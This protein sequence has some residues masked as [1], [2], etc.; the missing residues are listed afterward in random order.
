MHDL[1]LAKK[2]IAAPTTHPLRTAVSKHKARLN[3]ELTKARLKRGFAS[4]KDLKRQVE[5]GS[6]D[7]TNKGADSQWPQIDS[8]SVENQKILLSHPRWVRINTLLSNL[9]EQLKTT[10]SNYKSVD[11]VEEVISA[12][13][14]ECN[15]G[16]LLHID[17]HVPNI[18]AVSLGSNIS[19]TH[20]YLNGSII[21]Q[22]KASCFPAYLLDPQPDGG[23]CLDACA[24]PGNKTTHLVAILESRCKNAD[25]PKVWAC[26]RDKTRA[27]VLQSMVLTAGASDMVEIKVAQDF[28][29]LRSREAPWDEVSSILLDP[30]CSGSGIIG[31][32]DLPKI[33]LPSKLVDASGKVESKKTKLKFGTEPDSRSYDLDEQTPVAMNDAEKLCERLQSLSVF[34]LKLI[35]HAFQFPKVRRITYSTC[36]IYAE[37]NEH[38]V[39]KA[40]TSSV[41]AQE[42]WHIL[43]RDDQVSGMKN[44]SIRG[45]LAACQGNMA[46]DHIDNADV[47]EVANGCIR[48]EKGTKEGTQ[49][50]FVAAF[51]R[52]CDDP[53]TSDRNLGSEAQEHE[54]SEAQEWNGFDD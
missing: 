33:L 54:D 39:M 32:E 9:D 35:M 3:A 36:S 47:V 24:A 50:F 11:T 19:D 43:R 37:E 7:N 25:K 21:L 45:D 28:L 5:I 26:E 14:E 44:W 53:S 17:K 41:A 4:I 18:I 2:G 34:Q 40:L 38:V 1:L 15:A 48:C 29:K 27:L 22:D 16:K 42:G 20:A 46:G 10:F 12:T 13:T 6:I 31:R 23:S 8:P 51:I 52:R 49:G 30:S